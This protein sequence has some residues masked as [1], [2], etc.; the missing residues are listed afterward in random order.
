LGSY[1]N[2]ESKLPTGGAIKGRAIWA[3]SNT[4]EY[5]ALT[6]RIAY[7]KAN[8]TVE[9]VNP[10]FD[11]FRQFGPQGNAIA[12]NY[13]SANKPYSVLT[14]GT[15][16]DPGKWFVMGEWGSFDSHSVFGKGTSWYVSSGYRYGKFTP[17]ITYA[18]S[19]AD[20]R[21]DPGLDTSA[22]PP[23][24]VGPANDL[25]AALNSVLSTKS[26]QN[27][28]SVGGRWDFMKNTALKLQFDHTDI[29]NGSAGRLINPQPDFQTGGKVNLFSAT[30]DFVF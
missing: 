24:L 14:L 30:I 1:G 3:I 19:R 8:A 25:N 10:L 22:L 13:D 17:Y 28:I 23:F 18:Q 2:S 7:L 20:N 5:G 21:L 9:S 29:G 11:A 12:D 16:Y 15:S 4:S 6:V 27:T 26:V